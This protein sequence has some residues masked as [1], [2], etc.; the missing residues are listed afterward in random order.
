MPFCC[1]EPPNWFK[2]GNIVRNVITEG[3]RGICTA[4][5]EEDTVCVSRQYQGLSSKIHECK[6]LSVTSVQQLGLVTKFTITVRHL[7]SVGNGTALLSVE[8]PEQ[9]PCI[10]QDL[11]VADSLPPACHSGKP[12]C[13]LQ[14]N[15]NAKALLLQAVDGVTT[16]IRWCR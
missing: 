1:Q 7:L 3:I 10:C 6:A 11:T 13:T 16:V 5:V 12:L 4:A 2:Q 14:H 8:V 9:V 15:S